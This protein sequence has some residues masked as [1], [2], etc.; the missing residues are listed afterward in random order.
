MVYV[1]KGY[2]PWNKGKKQPQTTSKLNPNWKGGKSKAYKTCYYSFEYKKWRMQVF[3][4]DAFTCQK[5]GYIGYITAH[6]IKSF[7]NYPDL[8]FDLSNG[9]TLCEK[10]HSETDNYKGKN[11]KKNNKK[12]QHQVIQQ[13]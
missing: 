10:Y 8:R 6:H 11:N 3:E 2:K 9:L 7:A 12:C 5:C 1:K 13:I 4:R